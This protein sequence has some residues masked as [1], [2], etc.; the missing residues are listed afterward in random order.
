M[1]ARIQRSFDLQ[2]GVHFTGVFYLNIYD[3]DLHFNVETENI[4]EQTI[5]LERI[6]FYLAECLE[7]SIFVCDT[8]ED[9]IE[10]YLSA[11]LK[12]SVL[13]EEPY[14]QIVGIM[15]MTKL[16][17]ITEGRLIITD[18]SISSRMSDGVSCMQDIEDN[19]GPFNIK[20]WWNENN[21]KINSYKYLPK[22]KKILKLTKLVEWSDVFLNWDNTEEPIIQDIANEIVYVNFDNK[23]GK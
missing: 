20:D 16:N 12:V 14:D 3:I 18:I 23:T 4:K 7:N 2:M 21:T 5:A 19:I 10:R 22:N 1:T 17:A 11:N 9:A 6:K 8:Q 13:P 15:L